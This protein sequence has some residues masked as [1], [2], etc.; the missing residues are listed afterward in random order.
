MQTNRLFEIGKYYSP[1]KVD[2][3][4]QILKES[5]IFDKMEFSGI[6]KDQVQAKINELE[7]IQ[8]PNR[9]V[10]LDVPD[11]DVLELWFKNWLHPA[12]KHA[13]PPSPRD[14]TG[15]SKLIL[16]R[17]IKQDFLRMYENGQQNFNYTLDDIKNWLKGGMK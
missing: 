7:T 1:A 11:N 8:V 6:S 17:D 5:T 2:E 10:L 13:V 9:K 12:L 4:E 15:C 16:E 3:V 14:K